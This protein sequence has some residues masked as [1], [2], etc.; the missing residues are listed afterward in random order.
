MTLEERRTEL[1]SQLEHLTQNCGVDKRTDI[2]AKAYAIAMISLALDSIEERL[3]AALPP[4]T[5]ETDNR[6]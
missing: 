5:S 1:E 2:I 3:D 4:L 6:S